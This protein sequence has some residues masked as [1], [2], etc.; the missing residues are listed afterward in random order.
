MVD[1]LGEANLSRLG[2]MLLAAGVVGMPLSRNLAM[3]AIAVALIPLG[4]AFTFP[5]VTALLSRVI[6]P[7]Q[8]GLYMGMQQTYGGVARIVA[9]LFFGWSFDSLGVSSPY[10]FSSAFIVATIFLGFGLDKYA[11]PERSVAPEAA[12]ASGSQ[13]A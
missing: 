8:R 6:A 10:F 2:L 1:W 7:R 13:E 9:P 4:T 11:R 12:A 3:L 5:C